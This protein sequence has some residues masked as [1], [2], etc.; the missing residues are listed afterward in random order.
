M[1]FNSILIGSEDPA[2]T[3]RLLHE[4]LRAARDSRRRL[5]RLA[6]RVGLRHRRRT[7][8]GQGQ[9]RPS[10]PDHLEHRDDGRQGRIRADQGR[11]RDRRRRAVRLRGSRDRC[12]DRHVRRPGRQL[13]PADEPR[14]TDRWMGPGQL[15]AAREH[16]DQPPELQGR[17]TAVKH[18]RDRDRDADDAVDQLGRRPR[19]LRGG[20][21]RIGK[22]DPVAEASDTTPITI[23]AASTAT[24]AATRNARPASGGRG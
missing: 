8:R 14:W 5:H 9:E 7:R 22:Q 23:V 16:P 3:R 1:N 4:A 18:D 13:L 2:A 19:L 15:T 12:R 24:W 17:V 10:G 11:R 6:D 20:S 21:R